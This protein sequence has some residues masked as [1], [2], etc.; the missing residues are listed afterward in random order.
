ML[1]TLSMIA[2]GAFLAAGCDEKKS[3]PAKTEPAKAEPA[4]AEPAKAEPAPRAQ[5]Q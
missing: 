1:R 2:L 3:E 4:K 5:G